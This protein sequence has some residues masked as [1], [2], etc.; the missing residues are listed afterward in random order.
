MILIFYFNSP[1]KSDVTYFIKKKT[2]FIIN[3]FMMKKG[4]I[5][6]ILFFVV[7]VVECDVN[8]FITVDKCHSFMY[9]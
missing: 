6:F 3:L 2:L 4:S 7:W 1:S 8:S 9:I 5:F